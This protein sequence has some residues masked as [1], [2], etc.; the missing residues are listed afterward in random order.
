MI[1]SPSA[2]ILSKSQQRGEDMK[3][4]AITSGELLSVGYD[5]EL[6]VLEVELNDHSVISLLE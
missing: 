4:I 5:A 2:K 3:R 6:Q 1:D